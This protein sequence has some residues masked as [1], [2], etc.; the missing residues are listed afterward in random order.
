MAFLYNQAHME[1]HCIIILEAKLFQLS[2]YN[3]KKILGSGSNEWSKSKYIGTEIS[4]R[5]V[6]RD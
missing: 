4:P 6:L 3:G 2:K 1:I 5:Y